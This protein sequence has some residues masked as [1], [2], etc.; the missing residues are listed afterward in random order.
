[1]TGD[2]D[3]RFVS[4]ML[5]LE[6]QDA[7]VLIVDDDPAVR[8]ILRKVFARAGFGVTPPADGL[9]ALDALRTRVFGAV[10]CDVRMGSLDGVQLYGEIAAE[11]PELR[12]RVFFISAAAHDPAVAARIESTGRPLF[13]K[14]LDL[15]ALVHRVR[16]TAAG[17]DGQGEPYRPFSAH[18]AGTIRGTA[19]GPRAS[20]ICPH[21]GEAL[22][23]RT[24]R[25]CGQ[26]PGWEIRCDACHRSLTVPAV[27][28]EFGPGR[29]HRP[30]AAQGEPL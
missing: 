6:S 25:S 15:G 28:R 29:R 27:P 18:D 12:E 26:R 5:W 10:V 4:D 30:A 13:G 7:E 14:P 2:A 17:R 8:R 3:P 9:A 21:C 23:V 19:L 11:Y 20:L 22:Q 24:T 1:M 16:D